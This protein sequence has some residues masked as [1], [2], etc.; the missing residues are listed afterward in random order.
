MLVAVLDI[1]ASAT[2]VPSAAIGKSNTIVMEI[3]T[4]KVERLEMKTLI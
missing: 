3:A 1:Q 4:H 2:A